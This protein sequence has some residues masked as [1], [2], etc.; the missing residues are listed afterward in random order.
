M[1]RYLAFLAATW[2]IPLA[3]VFVMRPTTF[4]HQ[5]LYPVNEQHVRSVVGERLDDGAQ[6]AEVQLTVSD[7]VGLR[8]NGSDGIVTKWL[9]AP[10]AEI[11]DGQPLLKVD[12]NSVVANRSS[13][14]M[15]RDLGAGMAG[16]D[17]DWLDQ[18]L[19]ATKAAATTTLRDQQYSDATSLAVAAYLAVHAP[20]LVDSEVFPAALTVYVPPDFTSVAELS[21]RVGDRLGPGDQIV[22][23]ARSVQRAAVIPKGPTERRFL[24]S[25]GRMVVT[26]GKVDVPVTMPVPSETEVSAL[27]DALVAG[28]GS[29]VAE[30]A[31]ID[32]MIRRAAP[33]RLGSVAVAVAGS[34]QDGAMCVVVQSPDGNTVTRVELAPVPSSEAG[35]VFVD[36]RWIGMTFTTADHQSQPCG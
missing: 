26:V 14:P 24:V 9:V 6:R 25:E 33:L 35:V 36:E 1:K 4:E 7:P 17:V 28:D 16:P 30:A 8:W 18:L 20:N 12:G 15:Y 13:T 27:V 10:G 19:V 2:A 5:T 11:V 32:V 31:V 23:G 29:P 3:A 21:R 22:E 34:L